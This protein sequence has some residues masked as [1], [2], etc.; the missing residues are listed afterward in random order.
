M[1]ILEH[2]N[3]RKFFKAFDWLRQRTDDEIISR[4]YNL[5]NLTV[6]SENKKSRTKIYSFKDLRNEHFK[7][8]SRAYR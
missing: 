4:D 3:I 6:V 2:D 1:N 7:R 5:D 8:G